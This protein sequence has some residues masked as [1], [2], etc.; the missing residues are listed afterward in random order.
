[1]CLLSLSLCPIYFCWLHKVSIHGS[2]SLLSCGFADL[3]T[4]YH[5][6]HPCA[7]NDWVEC[8][9]TSSN[10]VECRDTSSDWVECRD[11][12]LNGLNIAE[13]KA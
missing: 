1:M 4:S 6:Y 12:S 9:D 2:T 10:W 11:T 8:R 13:I 7:S 3:L 5:K